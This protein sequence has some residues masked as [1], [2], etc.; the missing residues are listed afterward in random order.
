MITARGDHQTDLF[1]LKRRSRSR[2]GLG[3][4]SINRIHLC[5]GQQAPVV[6]KFNCLYKPNRYLMLQTLLGIQMKHPTH[7]RLFPIL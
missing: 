6:S 7:L 3:A 2:L 1:W 5:Q 4:A